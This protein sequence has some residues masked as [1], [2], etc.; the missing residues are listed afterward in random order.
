MDIIID[1]NV[2]L[3]ANRAAS[4][5]SP[6]C[7]LASIQ[8]LNDVSRQYT[9]R[10][11]IDA[12]WHIIGEYSHRLNPSGQ[13]GVGDGFLKWV[14]S[15]QFNSQRCERVGIQYD[16]AENRYSPFPDDDPE[17]ATFDLSDRKFVAVAMAHPEHPPIY[18]AT[19]TDWFD[20]QTPLAKHGVQVE[21]LCPDMMTT[22]G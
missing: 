10:L 2:P 14:L 5:A 21:F 3:V 11:V 1:T 9:H 4:Q 17:M 18:N 13:P 20:H 8:L 19:D 16:K 22:K 15:N 12:Q 7:V 6:A